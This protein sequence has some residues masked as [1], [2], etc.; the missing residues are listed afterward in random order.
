MIGIEGI[1]DEIEHPFGN[2]ANDHP[3][4]EHVPFSLPK[5]MDPPDKYCAEM[6]EELMFMVERL[7]EGV[8]EER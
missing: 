8:E 5:L 4:G 6:R 1:A 2:H 3:L 7:P